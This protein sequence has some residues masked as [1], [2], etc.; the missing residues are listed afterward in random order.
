VWVEIPGAHNRGNGFNQ[1]AKK[2]N[3]Q[4]IMTKYK[5]GA[6]TFLLKYF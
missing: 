1:E 6:S 4:E 3:P 5:E 2:F